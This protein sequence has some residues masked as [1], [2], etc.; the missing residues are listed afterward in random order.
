M[1]KKI[2]IMKELEQTFPLMQ[3][4]RFQTKQSGNTELLGILEFS[5]RRDIDYWTVEVVYPIAKRIQEILQKHD[6][7]GFRLMFIKDNQ[8]VLYSPDV[9]C[10]SVFREYDKPIY[11]IDVWGY[12][13]QQHYV[14]VCQ[15]IMDVV[16][17]LKQTTICF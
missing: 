13:E 7:D 3:F 15:N 4:L 2:E 8:F 14:G 17:Y 6:Y 9:G 5:P 16:E 11:S 10:G 12:K 1:D